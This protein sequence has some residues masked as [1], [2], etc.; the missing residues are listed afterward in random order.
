[1]MDAEKIATLLILMMRENGI[2]IDNISRMRTYI[3]HALNED[4]IKFVINE[5]KPI[6]FM[7][8]EI[9]EQG[10]ERHIYISQLIILPK[11]RGYNVKTLATFLKEKYGITNRQLHWHNHKKDKRIDFNKKEVTHVET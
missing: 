10:G 5:E 9:H 11:F 2:P 6:G 1:M 7:I 4:R 8:Y 3:Y